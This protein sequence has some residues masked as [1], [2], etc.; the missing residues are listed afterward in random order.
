MRNEIVDLT[1]VDDV[2]EVA[3]P[4][5]SHRPAS[6]DEFIG[7]DDIVSHLAI[8]IDA[9]EKAIAHST[10]F[11]WQV[12]PVWEKLHSQELLHM[13]GEYIFRLRVVLL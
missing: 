9:A 6:F 1:V 3:E 7:Q 4:A 12:L 5:L 8:M 11:C 13:K 10:I 2:D